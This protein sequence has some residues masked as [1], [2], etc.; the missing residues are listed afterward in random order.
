MRSTIASEARLARVDGAKRRMTVARKTGWLRARLSVQVAQSWST[1][2]DCDSP[3]SLGPSTG[4]RRAQPK[5]EYPRAHLRTQVGL[6]M[7]LPWAGWGEFSGVYHDIFALDEPARRAVGI[8]AVEVWR[9]RGPH[10]LP[11]AVDATASFTELALLDA[12]DGTVSQH[13]MSLMYSMAVTRLVNGIVDPLQRG[14]RAA[15]VKHLAQTVGL[16]S[17][18]VELRHECTHNRL[19]SLGRLRLA[20]DQALLWLHEHYW[21]PQINLRDETAHALRSCLCEYREATA[22]RCAAGDPPLKK[23]VSTHGLALEKILS[24]SQFGT[25]L[26]PML[27]DSGFLVPPLR[28]QTEPT[29]HEKDS[30]QPNGSHTADRSDVSI[31]EGALVDGEQL[32]RMWAP[33]LARLGRLWPKH[34]VMAGVLV[35]ATQRLCD[36]AREAPPPGDLPGGGARLLAL[37]GWCMHLLE[38]SDASE[39]SDVAMVAA[40]DDAGGPNANEGEP[41]NER[42][43]A[44]AAASLMEPA[45]LVRATWLAACAAHGWGRPV[46][47]RAIRH[48]AWPSDEL[49]TRARRLVQLQDAAEK[50]RRGEATAPSPTI[51]DGSGGIEST[52]ATTPVPSAASAAATTLAPAHVANASWR[53]CAHWVP[54]PI[55]APPPLSALSAVLAPTP[56]ALESEV[57]PATSDPDGV[58]SLSDPQIQ[59]SSVAA[60][61][62]PGASYQAVVHAVA[63]HSTVEADARTEGEI[64]VRILYRRYLPPDA[65]GGGDHSTG[66]AT[67]TSA[68]GR[69]PKRKKRG[70]G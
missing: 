5:R 39:M 26:L 38:A 14:S 45:A 58:P 7:S 62:P 57:Q 32:C 63:P 35:G 68:S 42:S 59:A 17:A 41:G 10:S 69:A 40:E 56:G 46:V 15:S 20:A 13:A 34:G 44:M 36:E 37:Q 64:E 61:A 1:L 8:R 12:E 24:A 25:H 2:A 9:L 21:L 55:G 50:V 22:A 29:A 19:P 52:L 27:L 6:R 30:A 47:L 70:R 51:G 18:L 67:P 4:K 48:T 66:D 65:G 16:P 49:R 23:H 11:L 31:D 43:G 3:P 53:V 60:P 33:L 28:A 54:T